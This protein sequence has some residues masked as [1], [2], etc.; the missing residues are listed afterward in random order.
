[1]S[2][3][4]KRHTEALVKDVG[5]ES[6]CELTGKS[7]ATL[8]RYYSDNPEHADRYMPVD[9]VAQ[10]EAAASYPHVTSALAEMRGITLSYDAERSNSEGGVNNDV[11]KLSQRFAQLMAEYNI[12]IED[13]IITVNEAKRLLRETTALQKVLIDMKLHLEENN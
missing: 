6:A 9:A 5:I 13:G 7:K 2:N 10:L 1:M 8:G 4:L 11:I 3:Y 12:S